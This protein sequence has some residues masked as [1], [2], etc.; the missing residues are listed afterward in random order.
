MKNNI[1]DEILKQISLIKYDRNKTL[2][3]N[4]NIIFEAEENV[5]WC[6]SAA[7][8]K[9]RQELM[10]LGF[11]EWVNSTLCSMR[12]DSEARSHA[13]LYY[14]IKIQKK[15]GDSGANNSWNPFFKVTL[16]S[17]PGGDSQQKFSKFGIDMIQNL[18]KK[19]KRPTDLMGTD[20]DQSNWSP[21]EYADNIKRN[22]YPSDEVI[23]DEIN[24]YKTQFNQVYNTFYFKNFYFENSKIIQS[25]DQYGMSP[26]FENGAWEFYSYLFSDDPGYSSNPPYFTQILNNVSR[27]ASNLQYTIPVKIGNEVG[28]VKDR[29]GVKMLEKPM[30]LLNVSKD[31]SIDFNWTGFFHLILPL[32]SL[33]VNIVVPFPAGA[34]I[35]C[36]L[37]LI[38]AAIYKYYDKDPYMTG[39]AL[40]FAFLPFVD[41]K[42]IPGFKNLVKAYNNEK[43]ALNAWWRRMGSRTMT[44]IDS[45]F[46]EN[47]LEFA[48]SPI[49]KKIIFTNYLKKN[50]ALL[51]IESIPMQN[52]VFFILRLT[53]SV[54]W[55]GFTQMILKIWGAT[56]VYDYWAS[57]AISSCSATFNWDE[58][59]PALGKYI[60][61]DRAV[62]K[63][64]KDIA[65]LEKK[66]KISI[67]AQPF[68][69]SPQQ[70]EMLKKIKELKMYEAILAQDPDAYFEER[71]LE[72]FRA[73]QINGAVIS[74]LYKSRFET[75]VVFLQI[76]LKA[77]GSNANIFS[78]I[79]VKFENADNS[80][81]S[82]IEK[83][84]RPKGP[85]LKNEIKII[86]FSNV[87]FVSKI[88][89]IDSI[90][91]K[92]LDTIRTLNQWLAT[93]KKHSIKSKPINANVPLKINVFYL[94]EFGAA[95]R[96]VS[97]IISLD[98]VSSSLGFEVQETGIASPMLWGYYDDKTMQM[99]INYQDMKGISPTGKVDDKTLWEIISDIE[100]KKHPLK[101]NT[102]LPLTLEAEEAE[103]LV[104]T[105]V[106]NQNDYD[107]T[108]ITPPELSDQQKKDTA[109]A[110]IKVIE[111]DKTLNVDTLLYYFNEDLKK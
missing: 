41:L 104:R 30:T 107:E 75:E 67:N 56:Y 24:K 25:L 58:M 69:Q 60:G 11:S 77:Y 37:E 21:E 72:A 64:V 22:P 108:T 78:G 29:I 87:E 100:T 7:G 43:L 90:S 9:V 19:L 82:W 51:F 99:V 105:Y 106:I 10:A 2:L 85:I 95:G 79:D 31:G 57:R 83:S 3:E 96:V 73:L 44:K 13:A 14:L 63:I 61:P 40:V 48:G 54:L 4:T 97:D 28:E 20:R 68:T 17:L 66:L 35:G 36:A 12:N 50:L 53:K 110:V 65:N 59:L 16:T 88:E 93:N 38:D 91:G 71:V 89:I 34:I 23:A 5:K 32:T 26:Y 84:K 111:F 27:I 86:T 70:C 46:A 103:N 1:N 55:N 76:F 92:V 15:I 62:D 45:I 47:L 49:G 80:V 109:N 33:I 8:R 39:F 98:A 52:M 94:G 42:Y 102:G 101:N 6:L 18:A 81:K 74:S